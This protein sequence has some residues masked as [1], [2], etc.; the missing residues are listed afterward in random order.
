MLQQIKHMKRCKMLEN[1]KSLETANLF[2][3]LS[4]STTERYIFVVSRRGGKCNLK[5]IDNKENRI[6]E[7]CTSVEDVPF[8]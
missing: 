7:C 8:V 4:V 6:S 3:L 5:L 1:F 2:Q